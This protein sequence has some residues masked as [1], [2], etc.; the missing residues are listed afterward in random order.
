MFT[1][2]DLLDPSQ[3]LVATIGE[4]KISVLAIGSIPITWADDHGK[5]HTYVLNDILHFPKSSVNLISVTA[6]ARY[7]NSS[8][9]NQGGSP[10]TI[11][12]VVLIRVNFYLA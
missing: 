8:F 3:S 11:T 12:T 5:L 2:Y 6:F 7:F 10:A 9:E 4:H 1:S